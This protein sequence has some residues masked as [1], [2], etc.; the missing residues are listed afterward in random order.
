MA[1]IANATSSLARRGFGLA[2]MAKFSLAKYQGGAD[3]KCGVDACQAPKKRP[4]FRDVVKGRAH[5][6]DA[7]EAIDRRRARD[8][9]A[10]LADDIR[11]P[12]DRP[13][14]ADREEDWQAHRNEE[15]DGGLAPLKPQARELSEKTHR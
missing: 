15:E 5:L 12:F 3:G 9:A 6:V 2:S 7:D 13:G 10:G 8:G 14:H 4:I 1:T 11:D